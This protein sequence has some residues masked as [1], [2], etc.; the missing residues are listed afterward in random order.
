MSDTTLESV[1]RRDRS[2]VLVVLILLTALTWAYLLWLKHQ[3]NM[4]EM[5][6]MDMAAMA[7]QSRPWGSTELAFG[8]VMWL[9]MMTGMMLP[10]IAPTILLYARVGR[11]AQA[12]GTPLAATGWFAGGYFLAW[13]VFSILATLLQAALTEAALLTPQMA[14]ADNILGGI[15]LI[16]AGTYQWSPFKERCL[17]KCRAPLFFIQRH[18]GFQKRALPSLTLGLRHGL[19]CIGCC[20]ALMLMLFVGGVMNLTWIA[21]IAALVLVE[22]T[23]SDGRT[24]SR[25]FG[26][27]L[28]L[29]GLSLAFRHLLV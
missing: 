18:G 28:I 15:L 7:P 19:F 21:G 27:G 12:Q 13:A 11:H 3:M 10:S 14:S 29:G 17:A 20:W 25:V 1:L 4:P 23:L 5:S 16:I 6:G 2:A 26:F 8:F 9:V 24:V 22:K